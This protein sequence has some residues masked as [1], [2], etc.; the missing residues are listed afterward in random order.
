MNKGKKNLDQVIN[1]K[2]KQYNEK[3]KTFK[4]NNIT[5]KKLKIIV[6]G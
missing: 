4:L 6:N 5:L 1:I 3:K 2:L